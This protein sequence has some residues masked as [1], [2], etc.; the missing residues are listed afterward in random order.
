MDKQTEDGA[1][2]MEDFDADGDKDI[3]IACGGNEFSH[4]SKKYLLKYYANAGNGQFKKVELINNLSVS[5]HNIVTADFNRD[6]KWE[7]FIGLEVF[8]AITGEILRA[9]SFKFKTTMFT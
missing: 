9:I 6:G 3:L 1:I 7:V 8:Q 4:D 5:S 2:L